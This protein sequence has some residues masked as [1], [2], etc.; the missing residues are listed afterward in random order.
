MAQ[1]M[2]RHRYTRTKCG[3]EPKP[4][5]T[6]K[7]GA[8]GSSG[9]RGKRTEKLYL[10]YVRLE[11]AIVVSTQPQ[12]SLEISPA[13]GVS[14]TLRPRAELFVCLPATEGL[15]VSDTEGV[16]SLTVSCGLLAQQ[17]RESS[18]G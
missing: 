16:R 9:V 8:K 17:C 13:G 4:R 15:L 10:V 5:N 6:S 1:T 2:A 3:F 14:H 18:S 7:S 12:L 11:R